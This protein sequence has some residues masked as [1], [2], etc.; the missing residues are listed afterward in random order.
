MK[1]FGIIVGVL[2]AGFVLIIIIGSNISPEQ[3]A[4]RELERRQ[5]CVSAIASS[6]GASTVGYA[7]KQA[8]SRHVSSNCDGYSTP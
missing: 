3:S 4:R 5:K 7:D 1:V 6:M 8:Y 2:L